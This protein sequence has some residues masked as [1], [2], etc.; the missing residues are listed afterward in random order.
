MSSRLRMQRL[1]FF[2]LAQTYRKTFEKNLSAISVSNLSKAITVLIVPL[3]PKI[4]VI[5][6]N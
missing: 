5:F 1:L 3:S 6:E 2:I 4:F